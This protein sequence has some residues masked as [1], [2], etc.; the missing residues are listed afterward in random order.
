MGGGWWWVTGGG[1]GGSRAQGCARPG[2]DR[3]GQLLATVRARP[4]RDDRRLLYVTRAAGRSHRTPPAR[5]TAQIR[6]CACCAAGSRRVLQAATVLQAVAGSPADCQSSDR[7]ACRRAAGEGRRVSPAVQL[8][9]RHQAGWDGQVRCRG[10]KRD[11]HGR[12]GAS[13]LRVGRVHWAF[14]L[15][16][17]L[18]LC[19][20]V[21]RCAQRCSRCSG[22][23]WCPLLAR[24]QVAQFPS[25]RADLPFP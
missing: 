4:G 11:T 5:P 16:V 22:C 15:N 2:T 19:F 18:F 20:S 6:S 10:R 14:G 23:Q 13:A 9:A 25:H 3:P 21:S 1:D 7:L 24:L 17:G 8:V 12:S